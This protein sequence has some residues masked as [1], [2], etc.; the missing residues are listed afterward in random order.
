MILRPRGDGSGHD[1][2]G[3]IMRHV[4]RRGASGDQFSE[5]EARFIQ[6]MRKMPETLEVKTLDLFKLRKAFSLLESDDPFYLSPAYYGLTGRRGLWAYTDSPHEDSEEIASP[7]LQGDILFACLHPNLADTILVFPPFGD[8][9]KK[10]MRQFL[11]CIRPLEMKVHLGRITEAEMGLTDVANAAF[12][13]Y[14]ATVHEKELILDW[15][16]PVQ[17]ISCKDVV[18]QKGPRYQPLRQALHQIE[19]SSEE[20]SIEFRPINF[21]DRWDQDVVLDLA[22]G[23][24]RKSMQKIHSEENQTELYFK[25]LLEM[26]RYPRLNLRGLIMSFDHRDVGFSIWEAPETT[27]N[28]ANLFASQIADF[29]THPH[30][31]ESL[32]FET[33]R[34]VHHN[35]GR[36][37]CLGGSET[38][39]L[40]RFKRKFVPKPSPDLKTIVFNPIV[41]ADL[42]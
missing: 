4:F 40:D 35:G 1:A 17:T 15:A 41:S 16:Y 30:L 8:H 12:G 32:I 13:D 6:V 27:A 24:L 10:I 23:W 20:H 29:E 37:L 3:S 28:T 33:A 34:E 7:P 38:P 42:P 39:T 9:A 31:S 11:H 2:G 25:K 36:N 21:M 19:R 18:R 26:G 14:T 22:R 5:K